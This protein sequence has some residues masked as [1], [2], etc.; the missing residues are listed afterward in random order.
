[1]FPLT[2]DQHHWLEVATE[3]EGWNKWKYWDL[4][5]LKELFLWLNAVL[6]RVL[7]CSVVIMSHTGSEWGVRQT[8]VTILF[9]SKDKTSIADNLENWIKFYG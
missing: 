9:F 7:Q 1:M 2:P 5:E 6:R 4:S 3:D 8:E